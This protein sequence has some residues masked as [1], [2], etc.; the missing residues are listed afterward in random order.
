MIHH[1]PPTHAGILWVIGVPLICFA[2]YQISWEVYG[3]NESRLARTLSNSTLEYKITG[4][5]SLTT[6]TIEVAAVTAQGSGWVTSSTISSGVPPG[7]LACR[8]QNRTIPAG[9]WCFC[10]P[11][12][13]GYFSSTA[14]NIILFVKHW[15]SL[16]RNSD[17]ILGTDWNVNVKIFA[18]WNF[19]EVQDV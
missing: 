12:V 19:Q 8:K 16:P 17:L 4:L 18:V 5:S 11:K 7:W 6:Y 13:M 2:G 10:V 9:S 14:I 15:S 1:C 3:R